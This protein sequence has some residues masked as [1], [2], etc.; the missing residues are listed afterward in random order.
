MGWD[1]EGLTILNVSSI[2]WLPQVQAMATQISKW[3]LYLE[4]TLFLGT[5]NQIFS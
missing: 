4:L 5:A 2:V 1:V 3:F